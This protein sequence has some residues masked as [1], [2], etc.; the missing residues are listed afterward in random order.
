MVDDSS[1]SPFP[2]LPLHMYLAAH[3]STR[4]LIRLPGMW[5]WACPHHSPHH[6]PPPPPT[7]TTAS[8][9]LSP[10]LPFHSPHVL[11]TTPYSPFISLFLPS[12]SSTTRVTTKLVSKLHMTVAFERESNERF[13]VQFP[14]RVVRD[15]LSVSLHRCPCPASGVWALALCWGCVPRPSADPIDVKL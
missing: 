3:T 10:F 14:G 13:R 1:S 15:R 12:F 5:G 8:D 6:D 11:V 4:P 2:R 9:L 7:T